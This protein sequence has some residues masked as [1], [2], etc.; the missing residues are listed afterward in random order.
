[1]SDVSEEN[2]IAKAT[3]SPASPVLVTMTIGVSPLN[4]QTSV[5]AKINGQDLKMNI[6]D[7][8][9]AALDVLVM[10]YLTDLYAYA[11]KQQNLAFVG[12]DKG[13]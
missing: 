3:L 1:M 2:A 10:K 12:E 13:Q 9:Q 6:K 5:T 4:I 7:L 11:G 8:P